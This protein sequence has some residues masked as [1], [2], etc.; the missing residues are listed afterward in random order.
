MPTDP[1]LVFEPAHVLAAQIRSREVSSLEVVDAHLARIERVNPA[2]RALVQ[3]RTEGA[4][5]DAATADRRLAAGEVVGPLHGLPFTVKDWIETNDLP[6][7]AMVEERRTYVPKHDATTVARLRAAGAILLGKTKPGIDDAVY[8]HA[9]NPYDL[10]RT[11]GGSS[12]GEAAIIAAG[13]SPLGLGSDSGGSLRWPAH[14][15]GIATLKPT[16]GLVPTTGHF[17]RIGAMSDPRTAIGPMAR[18]VDDLALA[19]P[20]L[21]GVDDRDPSV[22][23]VPPGDPGNVRTPGLRVAL[24]T[25]FP[26]ASP[27]TAVI[28]ATESA[29][30]SLATAGAT[31]EHAAPPRL[32][33]SLT[34]TEGYWKRVEST[35]FERWAPGRKST[36]TGEEF[37]RNLFEWDRFRRT[38]LRFMAGYDI[39]LCPAAADV[40]PLQSDPVT[41]ATYIYTLPFSLTGNPVV[42]VRA[43][44]SEGM[45][46]GVQV[47]GRMWQDATALAAARVIEQASGGWRRP[48]AEF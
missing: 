44:E 29:A 16:A 35:E 38:F 27:S 47:V 18:T 40:A 45:P 34:I 21:A 24:C 8:P 33:E 14:C 43:G 4:R 32:E 25:E 1:N 15:S 20:L 22:A 42:V 41:G 23:P 7:A 28:A 48:A 37:E 30:L 31:V 2:L 39:V 26:G 10:A 36:Q 13:G 12:A 6:C 17:P 3:L 9:R 19:L 5:A 11:P 46:V